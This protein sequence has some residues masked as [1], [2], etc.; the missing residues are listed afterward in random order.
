MKLVTKDEEIP[1]DILYR[2]IPKSNNPLLPIE[3]NFDFAKVESLKISLKYILPSEISSAKYYF[4]S[5]GHGAGFGFFKRNITEKTSSPIFIENCSIEHKTVPD[6]EILWNVEFL[7]AFEGIKFEVGIF[8]NCQATL[9][10]NCVLFSKSV[11]FIIGTENYLSVDMIDIKSILEGLM[12]RTQARGSDLEIA[13][14]LY[15]KYLISILNRLSRSSLNMEGTSLFL[16]DLKNFVQHFLSFEQII[17]KINYLIDSH[18]G[19][20]E[21]MRSNQTNIFSSPMMIDMID[22]LNNL[23]DDVIVSEDTKIE[24]ENFLKTLNQSI[25][26]K[27]VHEN[28]EILNGISLYFPEIDG[29]DHAEA[30]KFNRNLLCTTK[31]FKPSNWDKLLDRVSANVTK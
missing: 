22:F 7:E 11:R 8:N 19:W 28:N 31:T 9:F 24:L 1:H 6:F 18:C 29:F 3:D 23:K 10:E 12:R 20:I 15:D 30:Y 2:I 14:L 27:W 25:L 4:I 13:Q 16:I 21:R 26:S 5:I 17:E